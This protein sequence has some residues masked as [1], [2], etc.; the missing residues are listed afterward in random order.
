MSTWTGTKMSLFLLRKAWEIA[1]KPDVC[2]RPWYVQIEATTHCNLACYMCVRNETISRPQH[3][4]FEDFQ[5]LFD[6]IR[7]ARLTLSG[8]G[9]PLLNPDIVHMIEHAQHHGALTMVPSN[10]TLL[11][12]EGLAEGIVQA[13]LRT[14]KVSIDAATAGTYEAIRRQDCFDRIIEG[15]RLVDSL[16][17][18]RR[19][20]FPEIRFDVVILKENHAEIPAIISLPRRLNVGTVFFRALQVTGIGGEREAQIGR[21]VDF[22]ALRRAVRAGIAESARLGVRT[23]LKDVARDFDTYRSL[24]VR[25]DAAMSDQVCL[26]PWL[27]CF[28]SVQGELSPCCATYTNEGITAGNVLNEDFESVWNGRRMQAIRRRFRSRG[29]PPAVCRDCIPRSLPV[30]LKMGSMLPGFLYGRVKRTS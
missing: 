21:D 17:S 27:Q 26:L 5:R 20:R 18:Q 14:M 2:G 16:K 23:N 28:I 8:A 24:Y 22:D 11:C 6:R 4:S 7:P 13:G 19:S 9:E 3:L 25:Q 10:G 12:R 15:I 30:L 29:N 1:R